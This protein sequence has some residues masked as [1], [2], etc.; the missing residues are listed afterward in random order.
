MHP[1]RVEVGHTLTQT[2]YLSAACHDFNTVLTGDGNLFT[3]RGN[4]HN[5]IQRK[6]YTP[7][8]NR[9]HLRLNTGIARILTRQNTAFMVLMLIGFLVL[10]V[11]SESASG[12][13]GTPDIEYF[14]NGTLVFGSSGG[15]EH[16]ASE[17]DVFEIYHVDQ[18]GST[19]TIYINDTI[20]VA[21]NDTERKLT[22]CSYTTAA[23]CPGWPTGLTKFNTR[24]CHPNKC[25]SWLTNS[26]ITYDT[27]STALISYPRYDMTAQC[28]RSAGWLGRTLQ[29][30]VT[31][32]NGVKRSSNT[33][34]GTLGR[35]THK[36]VVTCSYYGPG[37]E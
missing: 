14:R 8:A 36:Y 30:S 29:S 21:V 10:I 33:Y 15:S 32:S 22:S 37:W 35:I 20:Y 5:N 23:N 18:S 19:T 17:T 24:S 1:G 26:A 27:S 6:A 25:T 16:N 3:L 4:A 28:E 9:S 2:M 34:G 13:V 7:T 11:V 31:N 12:D